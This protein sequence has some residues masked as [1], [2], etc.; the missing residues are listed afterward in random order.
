MNLI[1][2]NNC[3]VVL[4]KDKLIFPEDPYDEERGEYLDEFCEWSNKH[5]RFISITP[6]PI[7]KSNIPEEEL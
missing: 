5:D 1:S 3:G 4:D 2:C 6:C 7:C